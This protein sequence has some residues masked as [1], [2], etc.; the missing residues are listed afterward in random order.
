MTIQVIGAGFGRT[1]T[2]SMKAALEQL[3]FAPCH[4]MTEVF[5][6][7]DHAAGWAA[8]IRGEGLDAELLLGDY[9]ASVDFPSCAVWRQAAEQFP[10]A[11]VLLTV[12][13]SEDWWRSFSATIGPGIKAFADGDEEFAAMMGAM[14][15]VVFEGDTE[16][17]EHV[18]EVY[19]RH[20]AAV[21]DEVPAERLIVYEV[22]SGWGPLCERLG[23]PVPD[24]PYPH[25]NTTEE[26][27]TNHGPPRTDG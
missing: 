2:L 1:G 22:G 17:R 12:R 19:E 21:I 14:L 25:T 5:G 3:G 10:D 6:K 24:S 15:D 13:P 16:D 7:A 9:E 18:I 11:P 27:I 20:N 26:F 23:V 8:A 4:H